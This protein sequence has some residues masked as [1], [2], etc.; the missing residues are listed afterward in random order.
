MSAVAVIEPAIH[1]RKAEL[2]QFFTPVPVADFMAS[3]FGPLPNVVRMLDAGAGAGS[4]ASAFVSRLC[5]ENSTVRAVEATLFE[6]DPLIQDAL[7][8]TMNGCQRV[9]AEAGI[10]FSFTIH[11]D[12]FIEELSSQ[13]AGNLFNE[14]PPAF[15]AAIVN[16]PYRK[17]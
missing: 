11:A 10:R 15:D 8:D 9:C 5:K 16:P 13:L 2:G 1:D 4:L 17:I 7:A 3:L 6:I 12:D 14:K